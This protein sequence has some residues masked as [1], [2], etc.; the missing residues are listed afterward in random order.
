MGKSEIS[1][2]D[3]LIWTL[4]LPPAWIRHTPSDTLRGAVGG[5]GALDKRTGVDSVWKP[6]VPDA[7][8]AAMR[9]W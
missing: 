6:R 2:G 8:T 5:R 3:Q 1:G 7:D 4:M 9:N